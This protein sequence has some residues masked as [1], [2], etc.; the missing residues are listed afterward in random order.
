MQVINIV[1]LKSWFGAAP[2]RD[3][4]HKDHPPTP[5]AAAITEAEFVDL[6]GTKVLRVFLLAIHSH[7][8]YTSKS[9]LHL[10]CNVNILYRNLKSENFQDY[11]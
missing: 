3:F 9:G 6:V 11:A 8:Y 1:L 2:C 7:I 5:V 10:I 4:I